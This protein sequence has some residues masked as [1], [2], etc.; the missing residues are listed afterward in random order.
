MYFTL[1]IITNIYAIDG[2][3][4]NTSSQEHEYVLAAFKHS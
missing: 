1:A 2:D 3:G 4:V